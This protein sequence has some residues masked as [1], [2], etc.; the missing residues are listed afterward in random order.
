MSELFEVV[1]VFGSQVYGSGGCGQFIYWRFL[2]DVKRFGVIF[3]ANHDK[4]LSQTSDLDAERAA[5]SL[6]PAVPSRKSARAK[7]QSQLNRKE[8]QTNFEIAAR[9]ST[10]MSDSCHELSAERWSKAS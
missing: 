2:K 10:S 4:D 1:I 6:I 9:M 7:E 8:E 5:S 3:W